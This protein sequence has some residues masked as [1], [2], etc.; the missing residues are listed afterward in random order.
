MDKCVYTHIAKADKAV[1]VWKTLQSTFSDNGIGRKFRL[2]KAGAT[3][4]LE[5]CDSMESY[6]N[7][8]ITGWQGM[9]ELGYDLPDD[10]IAL[11]LL[12][13]LPEEYEPMIMALDTI[14]GAKLN[15]NEIKAKLL[16]EKREMTST[17]G[18]FFGKRGSSKPNNKHFKCYSCN[19][20]GHK[21]NQCP[22][23]AES[24]GNFK[25]NKSGAFSATFLSGDFDKNDWYIDSGATRHMSMHPEWISHKKGSFLREITA[26]N[27]ATMRVQSV[28]RSKLL[29][30]NDGETVDINVSNVLCIP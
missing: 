10:L 26:A 24:K 6:V 15:S 3:T 9:A 20:K 30:N 16:Q 8:I 11:F 13:G 1:D 2:V 14:K 19:R 7:Q 17:E 28:G 21:A 12:C 4:R 5:T 27:G 25:S 29:I 18:A 22:E 23:R